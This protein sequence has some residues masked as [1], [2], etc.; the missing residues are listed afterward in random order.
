MSTDRTKSQWI[1][2]GIHTEACMTEPGN[3]DT[4][5]GAISLWH[6]VTNCPSAGAVV[7]TIHVQAGESGGSAIYCGSQQIT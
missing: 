2:L 5:G 3:C 1:D 7:S 6:R 4:S